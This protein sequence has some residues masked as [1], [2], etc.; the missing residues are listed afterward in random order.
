MADVSITPADVGIKKGA[1]IT[2][3]RAGAAITHLQPLY[4]KDDNTYDLAIAND[5][6]AKANVKYISIS[7]AASGDDVIVVESGDIVFGGG[8][9]ARTSYVLSAAAAGGIA[10][11]SDLVAGNW[12]TRLGTAPSTTDLKLSI[13]PTGINA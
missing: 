6:E 2:T 8:L 3:V 5:T 10:P 9:T 1:R 11:E 7:K 4:S 13:N 12:I